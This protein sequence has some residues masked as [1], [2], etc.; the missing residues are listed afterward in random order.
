MA[1]KIWSTLSNEL[2]ETS[3]ESGKFVVC[4]QGRRHPA[5]GIVFN[6]ESVVTTHHALRRDDDVAV[7]LG[8]GRRLATRVVGRD[9]GTD[10]AVLR[11]E[12]PIEAPPARW[13]DS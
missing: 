12:Q 1:E 13:G 9:P 8:P 11:L 6:S 10:L 7:V 4:V 3:A 2:A 5:S